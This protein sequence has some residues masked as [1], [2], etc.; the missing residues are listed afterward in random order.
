[1]I[2]LLKR[3]K[4]LYAVYNFFHKNQL[5]HNELVFKKLGIGKK[6][7]SPVCSK[8][9]A[10]LPGNLPGNTTNRAALKSSPLFQALN[11]ASRESLLSFDDNGFAILNN[12]LDGD[13]VDAINNE[14]DSL[15]E[16]KKIKFTDTNKLMF[17]IHASPL[18]NGIGNNEPLK[19]LLGTLLGGKAALFQSINFMMGSE[20]HTHSDSI[21]MTTYPLGGLLG[22][23]IALED[24]TEENGP[25][26]YYPQSHKLPYYLN[27]D[28]N[29]EGNSW[30]L[31]DKEYIEY[32]AM[33]EE[34]I[35]E[36][37]LQPV[38]FLA[39][40]GD[41]LIWHANLFH[42]GDPHTDKTK[43][44]KS[45]VLHYFKEG[46]ICYHEI[47]QRPALINNGI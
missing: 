14:I 26:H 6:Y 16:Q 28:Y 22:A 2:A 4:W 33:M 34:K 46:C 31:G 39:K 36:Q 44:R 12:Y 47:T 40:K 1:M 21:H 23:W 32:E 24:V 25:L 11:P 10:G 19:E 5:V 45:M 9:F 20:Q 18:L 8:D 29:N 35:K 7:Y 37:Q 41:L 27:A 17:A 15:L 43:T 42:G 13:T 38:K 3:M 30:L